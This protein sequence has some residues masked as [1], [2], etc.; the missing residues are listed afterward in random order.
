[1]E[2]IAGNITFTKRARNLSSF[3]CCLIAETALPIAQRPEWGQR[4]VSCQVR[5]TRQDNPR[6]WTAKE[7]VNEDPV[8][9]AKPGP[10]RIIIGHVKP[11]TLRSIKTERQGKN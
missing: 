4:R 6:R 1:M 9:S 8:A 10:L 7:V 11:D 2:R 3:F 5:I